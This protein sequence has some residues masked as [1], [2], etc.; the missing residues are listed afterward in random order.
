MLLIL[1]I[2]IDDYCPD[3]QN[4]DNYRDLNLQARYPTVMVAVLVRNKAHSLPYFLYYLQQL[5]YPKDRM[6]IW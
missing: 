1:F 5:Q 6:S 4:T 3:A 2:C